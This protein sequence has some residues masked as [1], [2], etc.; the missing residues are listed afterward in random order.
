MFNFFRANPQCN[1]NSWKECS[2]AS[3]LNCKIVVLYHKTYILA[4]SYTLPRLHAAFLLLENLS[5][6]SD[7][8]IWVFRR[9]SRE[10]RVVRAPAKLA[11]HGFPLLPLEY[12]H[13][14]LP[15][16]LSS[17]RDCSQFAHALAWP[18]SYERHNLLNN[19]Y[20]VIVVSC[21]NA[22]LL[23]LMSLCNRTAEERRRKALSDTREN[24]F[25]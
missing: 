2:I 21:W 24:N 19:F 9:R 5:P 14:P 10:Q 4:H 25:V 3:K 22:S 11:A 17:K 15:H 7:C 23:L 20:L 18:A 6:M 16:R 1:T 13:I 8:N 12:S